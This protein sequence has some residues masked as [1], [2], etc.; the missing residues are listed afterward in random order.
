MRAAP[1]RLSVKSPLQAFVVFGNPEEALRACLKDREIFCE[2]DKFGDRYVRVYPTVES[3][4]PDIQECLTL[5][6]SAQGQEVCAVAR[7]QSRNLIRRLR[8]KLQNTC[9]RGI[10][11]SHLFFTAHHS[12]G[13]GN[14]KCQ[15]SRR[16]RDQGQEPAI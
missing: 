16:Q 12:A 7:A 10:S 6:T 8:L 13:Y 5:A 15:Q 3:D 9:V 1:D 14:A 4:L 11:T 2:G